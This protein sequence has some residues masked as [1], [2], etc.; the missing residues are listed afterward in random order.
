M[1]EATSPMKLRLS[2]ASGPLASGIVNNKTVTSAHI[3]NHLSLEKTKAFTLENQRVLCDCIHLNRREK[4][5]CPIIL[6]L[7]TASGPPRP[8]I[9]L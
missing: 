3:C 2:T 9:V 1:Q 7:S 4:A 6:G 8:A 5:K